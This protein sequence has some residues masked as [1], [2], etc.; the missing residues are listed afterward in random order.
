MG[1]ELASVVRRDG[2]QVV[3]LVGQQEPPYGL[4]QRHGP[5]PL[6]EPCHQEEVRAPLYHC[7]DGVA[8][9]VN[10]E[11]HLPVTEP[12]AVRLDGTLMY[13]PAVPD[14]RG[15]GLTGRALPAAV[16]HPVAAVSCQPAAPL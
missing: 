8:V 6:P 15:P 5:P 10:D 4:C 7:E 14:V 13:A 1:G 9:A 11:V 12:P 2:F 16:S 3:P